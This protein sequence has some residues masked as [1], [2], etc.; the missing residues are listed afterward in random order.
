MPAKITVFGQ[1]TAAQP[2]RRSCSTRSMFLT[3][4][5]RGPDQR[6]NVGDYQNLAA[7]WRLPSW[8]GAWSA[9]GCPQRKAVDVVGADRRCALLSAST[10]RSRRVRLHRSR[11]SRTR[12]MSCQRFPDCPNSMEANPPQCPSAE[13]AQG[14]IDSG[15]SAAA[16]T[17]RSRFHRLHMVEMLCLAGLCGSHHRRSGEVGGSTIIFKGKSAITCSPAIAGLRPTRRSSP[18]RNH[19]RLRRIGDVPSMSGQL[20]TWTRRPG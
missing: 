13:A 16:V 18:T 1:L 15:R 14:G 12:C 7:G 6:F 17:R 10:T 3:C 11:R 20:I 19:L 9:K 8:C 5:R 4:R 2:A